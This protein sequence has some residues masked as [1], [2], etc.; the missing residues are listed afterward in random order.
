MKNSLFSLRRFET[1]CV[2]IELGLF[3]LEKRKVTVDV[4][5]IYKYM[6]GKCKEDGARLF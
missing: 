3:S 1:L 4:I 2:Y 5:N 6:K